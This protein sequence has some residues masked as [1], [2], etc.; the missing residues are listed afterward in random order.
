MDRD[1]GFL[2]CD[3]NARV[4]KPALLPH[5]AVEVMYAG[6]GTLYEQSF[7]AMFRDRVAIY[8]PGITVKLHT[9]ESGVVSKIHAHVPHR[10]VVRVL[11]DAE[12]TRY[13]H[14]MNWIWLKHW[15]L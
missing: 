7:L 3:D 6:S 4:Y 8:P 10:P 11:T 9:G 1:Y 12:G 13:L 2:R 15:P 5:E 14:L